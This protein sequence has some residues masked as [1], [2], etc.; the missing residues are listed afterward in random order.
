MKYTYTVGP[1]NFLNFQLYHIS[2]TD[3]FKSK[4]KRQPLFIMLTNLAI[5]A[6]FA[7]DKK[8]VFSIIFV[9]IGLLWYFLYPARIRRH[10]ESRFENDINTKFDKHFNNEAHLEITDDFLR[11]SDEGGSSEKKYSDIV[12]IVHLPEETFV[13]F[14]NKQTFILPKEK[15]ENYSSMVDELNAKAKRF[16]IRVEDLPN[17]KW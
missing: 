13:I 9:A 6:Y 11:T 5:A 17:W 1:K 16:T 7:A 8:Y 4:L 15:I 2:Q 10:Y 3:E 14:K 12:K